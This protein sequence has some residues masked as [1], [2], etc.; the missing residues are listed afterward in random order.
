MSWRLGL[1]NAV[2]RLLAKPHLARTP[3]PAEAERDLRRSTRLFMRQPP[4]L[5]HISRDGLHWICAGT[6][7]PGKVILY[8]HGGGYVSGSPLTHQGPL[9]RLSKLAGVEVCAP[10][11]RLAQEAPLPAAFDDAVAAHD[12]VR[13]LGYAPDDIVLGG[14]SAGGG[15][16]LALL[17]H[18][19][20]IA[21]P[22]RAAFAFSPWTDLSRTAPS[23]AEN[24][25]ADPFLPVDRISELIDICLGDHDPRDPRVS[26]LYADF[27]GAPPVLLHVAESEILRDDTLRM[28]RR[29][30]QFGAKVTL[31]T[32][33]HAPHVWPLFDGWFP[34]ARASLR[35][36]AAFIQD[37]F[38]DTSR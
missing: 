34:E 10:V 12:R 7:A 23:L 27:P 24:A 13:A 25:R 36:T 2:L 38:A 26:P 9:G 20:A 1:T 31:D 8:F 18:C 29:L 3:G 5:R 14:D 33:P 17:A 30:E 28:A 35:R 32:L 6:C 22:P 21:E 19:C 37:S 11:Y 4:F 16:A 15:L